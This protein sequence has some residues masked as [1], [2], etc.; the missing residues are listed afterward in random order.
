M[1]FQNGARIEGGTLNTLGTGTLG[2]AQNDSA[3][4]DGTTE[5]TLNIQGTYTGPNNSDTYTLGTIN[6]TGSIAIT[7]NGN[8][9][10]LTIE[11]NTTLTGGG[12]VALATD[13]REHR[14]P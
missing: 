13:Q 2:T 6:N 12:T 4:L 10:Y 8:G 11:G 5:G 9:T 7:A 3:T 1:T 14:V